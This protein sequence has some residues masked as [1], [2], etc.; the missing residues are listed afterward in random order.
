MQNRRPAAHVSRSLS[1]IECNQAQIDKEYLAVLFA[2]ARFEQY[3][4][5]KQDITVETDYKLLKVIFL[6][7]VA[8]VSAPKRL[9]RT[10]DGLLWISPYRVL[11]II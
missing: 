1:P 4:F 5:G 9:Q 7:S 2:Y 6:M 8:L 11:P 10:K 3:L